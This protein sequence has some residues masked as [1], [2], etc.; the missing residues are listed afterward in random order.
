MIRISYVA[1]RAL[2]GH[3]VGENVTLSFSAAEMS[4]GR[5]LTR[6]TQKTL[7]GKR[8]TLLHNAL[9]TWSITTEPFAEYRL[10]AF[11]EF[12]QAVED[13]TVFDFEP[14]WTPG[15]YPASTSATETRLRTAQT[16]RCV[17]DSES[18]DL[19]RLIGHGEGGANDWYQVSFQLEEVPA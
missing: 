10:D 18:Y 5:K 6:D 16:V 7:S 13:G 2:D 4:P 14:W 9:R 19:M 8:E 1:T 15:A 11:E 3:A 17:L 12:I